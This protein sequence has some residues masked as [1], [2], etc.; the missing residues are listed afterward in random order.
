MDGFQDQFNTLLWNMQSEVNA[1]QSASEVWRLPLN[2][3][4]ERRPVRLRF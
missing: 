4:L 2:L 3:A 1:H